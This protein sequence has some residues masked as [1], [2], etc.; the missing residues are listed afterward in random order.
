[1]SVYQCPECHFVYD[2]ELGNP[3]EGLK[4]GTLW[5]SL[6][7]DYACPGCAVRL[8]DDFEL[9]ASDSTTTKR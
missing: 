6:P 5:K 7:E 3:H 9:Q 8:R 2:E 4:P 1:M